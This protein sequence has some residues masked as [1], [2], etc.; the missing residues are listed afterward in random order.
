MILNN[1]TEN[2]CEGI[3]HYVVEMEPIRGTY[4]GNTSIVKLISSMFK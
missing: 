3:F 1:T 2:A 4:I